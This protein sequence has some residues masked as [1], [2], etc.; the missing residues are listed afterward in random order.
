MKALFPSSRDY[1]S[2]WRVKYLL[3]ITI[4]KSVLHVWWK[5]CQLVRRF[6]GWTIWAFEMLQGPMLG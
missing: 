5:D 6:V 3:Y 1:Q 4:S 2:D